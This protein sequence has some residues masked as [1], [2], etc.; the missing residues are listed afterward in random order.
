LQAVKLAPV[1]PSQNQGISIGNALPLALPSLRNLPGRKGG[2]K[3]AS[4]SA[5][6]LSRIAQI[7]CSVKESA[8][9]ERNE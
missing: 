5:F 9:E 1:K 4:G 7:F 6:D 3:A 2:V 8:P